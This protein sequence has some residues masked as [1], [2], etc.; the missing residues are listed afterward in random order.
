MRYASNRRGQ[1]AARRNAVAVSITAL[2]HGCAPTPQPAQPVVEA[3]REPVEYFDTYAFAGSYRFEPFLE[4]AVA[5]QG[6]SE[7][8]RIARL[9]VLAADPRHG[10]DVF[11]LCRMLFD[12]KPVSTFRRPLIGGAMFI[13]ARSFATEDDYARWPLEPITLYRGAPFLIV[14]GYVLAGLPEHPAE[15]L[16]YCLDSCRWR[17]MTY[18]VIN[19]SER[20]EIAERFVAEHPE[21]SEQ[22]HDFVRQQAE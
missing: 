2:L 22:D 3:P 15:Y 16:E 13:G 19:K 18:A 9:K 17:D 20:M 11:V 21:L 8:A 1:R 12:A 5:L 6:M 4:Q 14:Q 7:L 10:S